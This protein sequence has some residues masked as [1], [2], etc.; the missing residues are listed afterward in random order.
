MTR[1]PIVEEVHGIRRR[2]LDEC[3]GDFEKYIQRLRAEAA[4]PLDRQVREKI[5]HE[6]VA[7]PRR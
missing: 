7:P 6:P 5:R 2:L 1:D 4:V 3:G